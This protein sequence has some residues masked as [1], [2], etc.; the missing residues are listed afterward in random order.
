META[1]FGE[2]LRNYSNQ[3]KVP[4]LF[5]W[6]TSKGEEVDFIIETPEG[7]VAIEG[8]L[9]KTPQ[10]PLAATLE[11]LS[12]L[13]AADFKN[14]YLVCL[15]EQTIALTNKIE[16]VPFSWLIKQQF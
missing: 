10:A 8:K 6:R 1:I 7:L 5:F 12:E 11:K 14:G 16:A 13:F 15:T 2:L 4:Q 3:G 9:T